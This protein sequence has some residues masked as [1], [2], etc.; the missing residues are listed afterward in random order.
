MP[1]FE[2][3]DRQD[4]VY[5]SSVLGGTVGQF[6]AIEAGTS[7][8]WHR[9]VGRDGHVVSIDTFGESAPAPVLK[10]HFGFTVGQI[11]TRMNAVVVNAR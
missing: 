2:L 10:E 3:F 11:V 5:Q 8:G 1:S 9:F 4:V 7:F 6:W